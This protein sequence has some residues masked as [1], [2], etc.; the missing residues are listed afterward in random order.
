M[1][2]SPK[3]RHGSKK[4]MSNYL[5][6][7]PLPH[8]S[9]TEGGLFVEPCIWLDLGCNGNLLLF[10]LAKVHLLP[11]S[12]GQ[13]W[14]EISTT[15]LLYS[16]LGVWLNPQPQEKAY[17]K[18]RLNQSFLLLDTDHP[19]DLILRP[20]LEHLGQSL[21]VVEEG[22]CGTAEPLVTEVSSCLPVQQG[23]SWSQQKEH[24]TSSKTQCSDHED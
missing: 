18:S 4:K 9:W 15:W 13:T 3:M 16:G 5:W 10:Y 23:N 12:W 1:I 14:G 6:L 20:L 22:R 17:S 2:E 19:G 11:L 7:P 24:L 8:D 21:T